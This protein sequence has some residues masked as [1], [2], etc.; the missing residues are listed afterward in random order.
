MPPQRKRPILS[1]Q[2]FLAHLFAPAKN[3]L[4]VGIRKRALKSSKGY[5]KRRLTSYNNMS[6]RSQELLR[7]S[8]LRDSYLRGESTLKDAKTALRPKAVQY[9]IAKPL[10]SD[11]RF[12]RPDLVSLDQRIATHIVTT[13]RGDGRS[14]NADV[15]TSRVKHLPS[16]IKSQVTTWSSGKIRAYAGD[17]NNIITVDDETVFNPLWYK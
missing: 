17:E 5:V 7:Q 3:P 2:S 9:G 16:K 1:D 6:G 12:Q 11:I 14:V 15:I 10:K 4:P 13:L 8:G